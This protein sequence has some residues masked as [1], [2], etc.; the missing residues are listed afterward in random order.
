MKL[1]D[2]F[3]S[4]IQRGNV[5]D[6]G[7]GIIMGA[8]FQ[9]IVNTLVNHVL[10]PPI[11]MLLGGTDFSNLKLTLKTATANSPEV[12]LNYGLFI[13]T[14][15]DFMIIGLSVF[16]LIKVVNTLYREKSVEKNTKFCPECQLE[17]PKKAYRCGHCT[18]NLKSLK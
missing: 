10:M 5:I 15:I 17:I 8:S 7:V 9:K 11:G 2:E 18:S 1:I 4:F 13:N 6:M 14:L 12:T 16:V 3:K